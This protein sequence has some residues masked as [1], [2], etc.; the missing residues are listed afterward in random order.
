MKRG[1]GAIGTAQQFVAASTLHTRASGNLYIQAEV[2]SEEGSRGA[3]H[4][5]LLL[6][7]WGTQKEASSQ[8]GLPASGLPF[9]AETV[10]RLAS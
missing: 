8:D 1:H 2:H 5:L 7:L 9:A 6:P 3:E 10:V 4:R